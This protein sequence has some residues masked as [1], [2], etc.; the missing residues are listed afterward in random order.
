MKI[1]KLKFIVHVIN[2]FS[3]S[4]KIDNIQMV[5]KKNKNNINGSTV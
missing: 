2:R 1:L 4:T 3:L 5:T